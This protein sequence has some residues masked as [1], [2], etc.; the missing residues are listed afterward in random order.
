[1]KSPVHF[2]FGIGCGVLLTWLAGLAL[3]FIHSSGFIR[4]FVSMRHIV[5]GPVLEVGQRW[6]PSLRTK[7][8]E[9]ILRLPYWSRGV[10][11]QDCR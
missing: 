4:L 2:F 5:S 10:C 11:G 9:L 7:L 6:I 8:L 3:S 1:M